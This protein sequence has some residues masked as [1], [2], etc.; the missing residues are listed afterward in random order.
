MTADDHTEGARAARAEGPEGGPRGCPTP[1]AGT[2][3]AGAGTGAPPLQGI[4][5][6]DKPTGL[7]SHDVVAVVRRLSRQ[8]SVGHAG[9]L[10]PLAAGVL[11]VLLGK[12]TTLS[13]YAMASRKTYIGD[14]AF[15]AATDT[16][17]AEGSIIRTAAV[18]VLGTD[19]M[20]RTLRRFVGELMQQ[21]P[22]FAAIKSGGKK[23]Y[24][25]ARAGEQVEIGVRP[26]TVHALDIIDWSPPKLRLRAV[27]G[28]GTYIRALA[29]DIG[30]A[31]GSAA[32]LHSLVRVRS[33]PFHLASAVTLDTLAA[34]GIERHLLPMDM[35]LLPWPALIVDERGARMVGHGQKIEAVPDTQNPEPN[36][37]TSVAETDMVRVYS[38]NGRFLALARPI[39]NGWQPVRVLEPAT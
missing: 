30:E 25:A 26:V 37:R 27:V 15:G 32:Y 14:V 35:A 22:R 17:D 7:T 10:D 18:P 19:E 28:S 13:Q 34:D 9:T 11:V 39:E 16:D 31:S 8:R 2:G 29:R 6:V 1:R 5:N 38:A 12:A 23:L 36:A 33:G 24:A 4:V 20:A 3:A 21:P